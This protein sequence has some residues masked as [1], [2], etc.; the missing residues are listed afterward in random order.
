MNHAQVLVSL[1]AAPVRRASQ[2]YRHPRLLASRLALK[3]L[4]L[5][6]RLAACRLSRCSTTPR[7]LQGAVHPTPLDFSLTRPRLD[8]TLFR[9]APLPYYSYANDV[10]FLNGTTISGAAYSATVNTP[11]LAAAQTTGLAPGAY[12]V[13]W[14]ST[15]N[16]QGNP[17]PGCYSGTNCGD[18]SGGRLSGIQRRSAH[19]NL[20]WPRQRALQWEIYTP[21]PT[22]TVPGFSELDFFGAAIPTDT[23]Q[24][25]N[26][27]TLTFYNGTS[28]T[29][30][31]IYGATISFYAGSPLPE[32]FS[33]HRPDHH[34]H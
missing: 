22:Q 14:A 2:T 25:F 21:P 20:H 9:A 31:L 33:R 16:G 10:E 13:G 23:T 27:G 7:R 30:T 18:T 17:T 12:G 3:Q 24:P 19:S 32:Q 4:T 6:L 26:I 15:P 11:N 5:A 28:D 34:H 8:K 1:R 29:N